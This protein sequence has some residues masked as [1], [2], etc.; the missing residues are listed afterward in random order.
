MGTR[1]KGVIKMQDD[2]E[3][4]REDLQKMHQNVKQNLDVPRSKNHI[5][6]SDLWNTN[7]TLRKIQRQLVEGYTFDKA[8]LTMLVNTMFGFINGIAKPSDGTDVAS[9]E[10]VEEIVE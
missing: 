5:K 7:N 6:K 9:E 4:T 1:R 10:K 8:D 3:M 2:E